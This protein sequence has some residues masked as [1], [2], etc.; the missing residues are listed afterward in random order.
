MT[1]PALEWERLAT[2]L[3]DVESIRFANRL[4]QF[5]REWLDNQ[6]AQLEQIQ[7]TLSEQETRLSQD[8]SG[9]QE[10]A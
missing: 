1:T 7:R 10:S 4:I 6:A 3:N 9:P 2:Q 8:Q 5:Q